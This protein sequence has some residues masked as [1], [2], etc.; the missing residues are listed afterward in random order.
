VV[1]V[2]TNPSGNLLASASRD[3]T[4]KF[5][6]AMSGLCVKTLGGGGGGGGGGSPAI[7]E[8]TSL[9]LGGDGRLVLTSSRHGPVRLWDLRQ[10][11]KPLVRYAGH[12]NAAASFVR[13]GFGAKESSVVSGSD[14]GTVRVWDT[15]TGDPLATLRGHGGSPVHR[16]LWCARQGLLASCAEDGSVKTWCHR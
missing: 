4:V 1:Q 10:S 5:W 2:A 9:C 15:A 6:D 13:C 7:G 3:G 11:A 12:Q 8:A 14:D 16:A